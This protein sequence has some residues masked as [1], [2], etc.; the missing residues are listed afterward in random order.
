MVP[1]VVVAVVPVVVVM[2][3]TDVSVP[4]VDI[5]SV[6]IVLVVMDV[7]VMVV[8]LVS[9]IVVALVS[10]IVVSVVLTFDSCLHAVPKRA[11]ATI[12]RST[13]MVFFISSP[14]D[15]SLHFWGFPGY[16]FFECLAHLLR[17]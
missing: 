11:S 16:R 3:V 12:V 6:D 9:V 15:I 10:V 2:V 14:L 8:E 1:L 5:V 4:V 17:M 13:R 7:S